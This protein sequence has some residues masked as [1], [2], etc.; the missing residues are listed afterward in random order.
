MC[1]AISSGSPECME[2]LYDHGYNVRRSHWFH[3]VKVAVEKGSLPCLQV[4]LRRGGPLDSRFINTVSVV[5]HGEEML[6]YALES[7]APWDLRTYEAAIAS[8]S[9]ECLKC[10]HEFERK[11]PLGQT[12]GTNPKFDARP[13]CASESPVAR[14]LPVLLY[15]HE[16]MDA[17]F[18]REVLCGTAQ[19]L[20]DRARSSKSPHDDTDWPMLLY[21][22]RHLGHPLPHSLRALAASRRKRRV[23][24]VGALFR[25]K[26]LAA[27]CPHHPSHALWSAMEALP[28]ELRIRIA[29]QAELVSPDFFVQAAGPGAGR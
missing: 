25:A 1:N 5:R 10:A 17:A 12:G 29:C 11:V 23:A 27:E 18:A 15:V 7:G 21:I 26:Q 16:H 8:D 22:E 2:L 14:S 19:A 13:L 4:A 28:S 9:L 24:F 6:R 3:P 20:A